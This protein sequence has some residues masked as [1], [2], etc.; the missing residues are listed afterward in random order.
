MS[1]TKFRTAEDR[2]DAICRWGEHGWR[3]HVVAAIREA[4]RDQR[5]VSAEAI[6]SMSGVVVR[7]VDAHQVAMNASADRDD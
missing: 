5:H 6:Q 4:M 2:A 3:D 1:E 7:K